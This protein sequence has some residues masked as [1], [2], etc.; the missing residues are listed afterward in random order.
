MHKPRKSKY[1]ET[2][3]KQ[4]GLTDLERQLLMIGEDKNFLLNGRDSN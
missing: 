3:T 1:A 4:D 2:P